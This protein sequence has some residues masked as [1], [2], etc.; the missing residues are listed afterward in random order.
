MF[1]A[2]FLFEA[3]YHMSYHEYSG[4]W[5][6]QKADSGLSVDTSIIYIYIHMNTRTAPW[7]DYIPQ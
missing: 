4:L 2:F 7:S 1:F 3:L 6:M 5:A